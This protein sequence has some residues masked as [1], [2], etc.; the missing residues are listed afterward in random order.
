MGV[1]SDPYLGSL[2]DS[3]VFFLPCLFA[4]ILS[5]ILLFLPASF[6]PTSF[7]FSSS[8]QQIQ[9]GGNNGVSGD[10]VVSG[11]GDA[12]IR[13]N[14][15]AANIVGTFG[16][17]GVHLA[18]D[19]MNEIGANYTVIIPDDLVDAEKKEVR[20]TRRRRGEVRFSLCS[21]YLSFDGY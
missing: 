18:I 19:Y 13:F 5:T 8:K 6:L 4:L 11:S 16:F 2:V 21:H 17:F 15:D 7:S 10:T 20:L 1:P 3:Q 12:M 9:N 14:L